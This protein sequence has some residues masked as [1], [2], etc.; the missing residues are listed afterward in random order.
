MPMT[1]RTLRQSVTGYAFLLPG[2][3]AFILF[4]L[5]PILFSLVISFFD[6]N[7]FSGPVFVDTANYDAILTSPGAQFWTFGG[8]SL[9][10]LLVVP[11]QMAIALAAAY[12]LNEDVK[13]TI[14]FKVLFF[15]PVVLSVVPVSIIW[16]YILDS[17]H[18]LLNSLLGLLGA[19]KIAWLFDPSW[20]KPGIALMTVWQGSAFSTIV[21][22][23]ALQGIP[24][25]LYEVATLDG[26]GRWKKFLNITLPL[27]GPTHIFLA[28][29]G[30]IGALQLFAPIMV[31]THGNAGGALTLIVEVYTKAYQE[32]RMGYASALAWIL[33]IGIFIIS[34]L[35]WKFHR[36]SADYA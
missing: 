35:Y 14:L 22:F 8:N 12:L 33:F 4:T 34:S 30:V 17:E 36:R 16:A 2:L 13:G 32:F 24:D 19:G 20:I 29:T 15:I 26:A 9:F 6:W 11:L 28:V 21:Y 7:L 5:G 27:L 3:I 31:M 10:F 1:R 18:G 25:Q 23:A